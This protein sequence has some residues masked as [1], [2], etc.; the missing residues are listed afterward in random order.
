GF[1]QG[2]FMGVATALG[3][4]RMLGLDRAQL[5]NAVSLALVP[6]I[7]LRVTR[8]GTL[9]MWKGCASASAIHSA[10]FAVRL[11]RNGMTGPEEPFEGKTGLWDQATGAFSVRLPAN[12]DGHLVVEISHLKQFPAET[13]GQALLGLM[14]KVR[15]W[16]SPDQIA[17]IEIDTYWQAYHE[18]AMHPSR[19]DPTTRE[20]ADHSL[21]YLLSVALVDG[22]I[23]ARRS[24]EP[25]RISDPALRPLMNKISVREDPEFTAGFRPP[26]KGI[27]G[28]PRARLTV[29]ATDGER[30]VE[31]VGYHRGH[32]MNPMTRD[33]IDAKFDAASRGVLGRSQRDAI[34][35]AW[36]S[37]ADAPDIG[38]VIATMAT[39]DESTTTDE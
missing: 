21:P 27:S 13:H 3:I 19:W 12:D 37:V 34:R 11:A 7:P 38:D 17:S 35:A 10:I 22:E 25:E 20:T 31:E 5:G 33:D 24:F 26:G 14:P 30:L 16:R 9:S 39:F 29:T 4:G 36:W 2:T 8:T 23:D 1:D 6:H 15:A 32:W 18:I 28:E